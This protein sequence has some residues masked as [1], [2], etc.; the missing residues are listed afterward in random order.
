MTASRQRDW[1]RRVLLRRPKRKHTASAASITPAS[2]SCV[3]CVVG[4]SATSSSAPTTAA[5]ATTSAT[6]VGD[7][8]GKGRGMDAG[9][10]GAGNEGT[11]I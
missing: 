10:S 4:A 11:A 9:T 6:W 7:W 2:M 3:S 8:S 1:P 5:P